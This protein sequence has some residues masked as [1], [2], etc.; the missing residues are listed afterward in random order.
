MGDF[1]LEVS[2]SEK[3]PETAV[4]RTVGQLDGATV[5][6]F[7]ESMEE[8]LEN[9]YK[10]LIMDLEQLTYVNS[11][12]LGY[13]MELHNNLESR[14]GLMVLLNLQ[15]KIR[16]VFDMIGFSA[17]L[18]IVQDQAEAEAQ[19]SDQVQKGEAPK[20][21]PVQFPMMVSCSG[22]HNH[23]LVSRPGPTR[24]LMC[25][26]IFHVEPSGRV[27]S[28]VA[29]SGAAKTDGASVHGTVEISSEITF[30][31]H[32]RE[33]CVRF[34]QD[35]GFDGSSLEDIELALDEAATNVIEHAYN[36]DP[37]YLVKLSI[38]VNDDRAVFYLIDNGKTF[39]STKV[40]LADVK[41]HA[42]LRRVSGLGRFLMRTLMD[43]VDFKS[44]PGVSNTLRMVKYKPGMKPQKAAAPPA[45][46]AA[47]P[48][49]AAPA[50]AKPAAAPP[51]PE[52]P[53]KFVF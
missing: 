30:L 46:A 2:N 22:C 7:K 43:E 11:S 49:P 33:F 4:I 19:I 47:R 13:M 28:L 1:D 35:N 10:G 6:G 34:C 51:L 37:R 32:M 3:I 20:N 24:C 17:V 44:I 21:N 23:F 12:G 15:P 39:D 53:T 14:G 27:F 16:K 38:D 26:E 36:F 31:K 42:K 29:H 5:A 52:K 45:Q 40:A 48:A 25:R 9:P 50:A 41:T 8:V 18:R